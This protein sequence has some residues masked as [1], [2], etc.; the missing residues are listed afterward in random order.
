[1][2]QDTYTPSST[3]R[4][5]VEL[6]WDDVLRQWVQVTYSVPSDSA[7]SGESSPSP[8]DSSPSKTEADK[9][10]IEIEF[11]TLIGE[12]VLVPTSNSI[13][14]RVND[15]VKLVGLGKYLSGSYFVTSIR[16]SVD[17]SNSYTHTLTVIKTGFGDSLKDPVPSSNPESRLPEVVK[18][19]AG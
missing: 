12:M 4:V 15:T 19:P 5:S 9:E 7:P 16:R 14:I 8:S 13:R 6:V 1:M 11:N 10:Y 3:D 17:K 18:T 2:P